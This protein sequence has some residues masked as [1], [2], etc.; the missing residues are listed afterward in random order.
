MIVTLST[1]RDLLNLVCNI[2]SL[3]ILQMS[4]HLFFAVIFFGFLKQ[5]FFQSNLLLKKR[6]NESAAMQGK[7]PLTNSFCL[8]LKSQVLA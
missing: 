7:T 8:I 2:I 3:I 6:L 5:G 4:L 1:C